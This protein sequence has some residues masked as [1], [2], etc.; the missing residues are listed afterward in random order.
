MTTTKKGSR[1]ATRHLGERKYS[2]N[3][4]EM[5]EMIKN[6]E[7]NNG[8]IDYKGFKMS[9]H[10][11]ERAMEYF[12]CSE[13]GAY[14]LVRHV[15]KRAER[16]GEQLAYDGRI[17]IL[18][19]YD[20]FAIY[21]SPSLEHVVTVR[22]YQ[23]ISY[24]PIRKM[25]PQLKSNLEGKELK[26]E[27]VRLHKEAWD[28]LEKRESKQL[29]LVLEIDR[30]VSDQI[31]K[32]EQLSQG[33]CPRHYK[34]FLKESLKEARSKLVKEGNKLFKIKLQKRHVGKSITSVL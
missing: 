7:I 26:E 3:V 6:E 5:I 14:K 29:D 30:E 23:K 34:K 33:H 13:H 28:K 27:L 32:F 18:F 16:I 17:N 4:R 12:N 24:K 19:V 25:L 1:Y 20:Q 31:K 10:A 11:L 8:E 21:M 22:K 15:L 9:G 2:R